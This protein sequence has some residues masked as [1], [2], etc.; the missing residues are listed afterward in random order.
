M[1]PQ[2]RSTDIRRVVMST[3]RPGASE[4]VIAASIPDPLYSMDSRG[5]LQRIIAVV[6]NDLSHSKEHADWAKHYDE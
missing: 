1:T 2:L 3:F 6:T 5:K 4:A